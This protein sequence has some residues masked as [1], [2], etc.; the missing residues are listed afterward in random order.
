MPV[1]YVYTNPRKQAWMTLHQTSSSLARCE[2]KQ[3]ASLGLSPQQYAILTA[4]KLS[5]APPTLTQIAEWVDRHLNSITYIVDRMEKSG[6]VTRVK[7]P[8][9]RRAYSLVI[10]DKGEQYYQNCAR[11]SSI[12]I[13]KFLDCLSDEE[14]QTLKDMLEKIRINI[15]EKY[16]DK[17]TINEVKVRN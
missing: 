4:V 15:I 7:N 14:M 13:Q 16:Y 5:P 9:D 2:E 12:L 11:G 10:T 1:K 17:K 8:E 3:F 6:L